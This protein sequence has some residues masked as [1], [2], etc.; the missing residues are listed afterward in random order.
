MGWRCYKASPGA[1][2]MLAIVGMFAVGTAPFAFLMVVGILVEGNETT[3]IPFAMLD[4]ASRE[5]WAGQ[6]HIAGIVV[7]VGSI[8]LATCA[9]IFVVKRLVTPNKSSVRAPTHRDG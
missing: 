4:K 5:W 2:F 1:V 8:T 3:M 6:L 9:G 7:A